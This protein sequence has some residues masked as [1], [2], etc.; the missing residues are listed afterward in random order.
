ML[1]SSYDTDRMM[2]EVS[3]YDVLSEALKAREHP[4]LWFPYRRA[5]VS[6]ARFQYFKVLAT[7]WCYRLILL[8][9]RK[10]MGNVL[11][12]KS[13]QKIYRRL[14]RFHVRSDHPPLGRN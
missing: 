11:K 10:M 4:L 8:N 6:Y 5:A 14:G 2:L 7:C 3:V 1:T 13:E 9:A 12:W